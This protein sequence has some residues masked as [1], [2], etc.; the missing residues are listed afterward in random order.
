MK[1]A[2]TAWGGIFVVLLLNFIKKEI[3]YF[4][5][6]VPGSSPGQPT[7]I[8]ISKSKL[9]VHK[10]SIENRKFIFL[11]PFFMNEVKKGNSDK[12]KFIKR[13]YRYWYWLTLVYKSCYTVE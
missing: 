11:F 1:T 7:I 13:Y 10:Q 12:S 9:Y 6:L 5:R 2:S 8:N 3:I 4:I